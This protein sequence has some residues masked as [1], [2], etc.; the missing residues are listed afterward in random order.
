M[1]SS[2]RSSRPKDQTQVSYISCIGRWAFYHS[3]HLEAQ[4]TRECPQVSNHPWKGNWIM[5]V[6]G[7]AELWRPCNPGRKNMTGDYLR[8]KSLQLIIILIWGSPSPHHFPVIGNSQRWILYHQW[9][10]L[11]NRFSS[12]LPNSNPLNQLKALMQAAKTF[13]EG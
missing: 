8:M 2:R 7:T 6:E 9:S 11:L 3:L 13:S 12:L 5:M 10:C 4:R 1:P